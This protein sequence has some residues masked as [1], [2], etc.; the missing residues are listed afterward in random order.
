[1]RYGATKSL[2]LLMICIISLCQAT[3]RQAVK[4]RRQKYK[5]NFEIIIVNINMCKETT[6]TQMVLTPSDHH[7]YPPSKRRILDRYALQTFK[8]PNQCR[9]HYVHMEKAQRSSSGHK[10]KKVVP[11]TQQTKVH[12][13]R[14]FLRTSQMSHMV[15]LIKGISKGYVMSQ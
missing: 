14:R 4:T 7:L 15:H 1:M 6:V 9:S 8:K 13:Y 5:N 2:T 3:T 12:L 10:T 11:V